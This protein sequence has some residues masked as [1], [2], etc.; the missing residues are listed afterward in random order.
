MVRLI[1]IQNLETDLNKSVKGTFLNVWAAMAS[2]IKR[3]R[4]IYMYCMYSH[5]GHQGR[6]AGVRENICSQ[7]NDCAPPYIHSSLPA[8]N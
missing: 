1:L 5:C 2:C 3:D 7:C 4:K 8:F 6:L